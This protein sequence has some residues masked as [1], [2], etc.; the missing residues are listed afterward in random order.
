ML[1]QGVRY[2][3]RVLAQTRVAYHDYSYMTH[4]SI[5]FA[6]CLVITASLVG[7]GCNNAATTPT[8][9]ANGTPPVAV[10]PTP[11]PST[12]PPAAVVAPPSLSTSTPSVPAES[13]STI[14]ASGTLD[15][16]GWQTYQNKTLKY[17]FQYPLRGSFAPEFTVKTLALTS[18]EIQNDCAKPSGLP[19]ATEERLTVN[20]ASFCRTSSV[21]G[22][23]GSAY[24]QEQW[25]T[26]K[27][28]WYSVITFTKKYQND[29]AKPFNTA[30]YRQQL[31]AIMSTFQYPTL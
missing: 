31:E 1:A 12:T 16:T 20:G 8:D 29:P 11:T 26:K 13:P 6:A 22:A 24:S 19:N 9:T 25:V 28:N 14:T 2:R 10:I 15:T 4:K 7:A 18:E 3:I 30:G 21:E 5:P 17:Q 27:D 23:A